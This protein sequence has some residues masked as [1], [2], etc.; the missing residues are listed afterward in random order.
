M[1]E[2][3]KKIDS[4]VWKE[5]EATP[6]VEAT[7]QESL[8]KLVEWKVQLGETCGQTH[9]IAVKAELNGAYLRAT[10]LELR[11]MEGNTGRLI[12][13]NTSRVSRTKLMRV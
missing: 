1:H 6:Q 3:T 4:D 11:A 7:E 9:L 8:V 12:A 2:E 13:I 10:I 5:T